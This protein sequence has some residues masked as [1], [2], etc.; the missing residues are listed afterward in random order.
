MHEHSSWRGAYHVG[1]PPGPD[2]I[3]ETT[4]PANLHYH[5]IMAIYFLTHTR[6]SQQHMPFELFKNSA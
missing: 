2:R 1:I 6:I 5:M 4:H 3:I